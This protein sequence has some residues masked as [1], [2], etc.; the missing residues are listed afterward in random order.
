MKKYNPLQK[1]TNVVKLSTVRPSVSFFITTLSVF[2]PSVIM[3][4]VVAPYLQLGR[5][6]DVRFFPLFLVK[7]FH[8]L[9]QV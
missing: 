9:D 4:S 2:K 5:T 3:L 6:F 1:V 7:N 8:F